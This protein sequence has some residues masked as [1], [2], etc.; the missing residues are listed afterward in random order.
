MLS[1]T[2]ERMTQMSSMQDAVW[3]SNS[4][5]SIPDPP[6]FLNLNGDPR[7]LPVLVRMSFGISN[8][9][10]LPESRVRSGLC[11]KRSTWLGPPDMKRKM[12]RLARGAYIGARGVRGLEIW[13]LRFEI[14]AAASDSL[15]NTDASPS[16]PNPL[17]KCLSI[18]RREWGCISVI[19]VGWALP[20]MLSQK[21]WAMPTLH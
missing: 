11:S 18:C 17:A 16:M 14:V 3:G 5:T 15:L 2:I 19:F 13:D 4:E 1:A 21:R 12:T 7:R 9:S 10:G 20:T 8:G 6:C